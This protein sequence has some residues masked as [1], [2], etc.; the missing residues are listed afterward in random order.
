VEPEVTARLHAAYLARQA[1]EEFL[2]LPEL[3]RLPLPDPV[4]VAPP[5]LAPEP[6]VTKMTPYGLQH[7]Y[8]GKPTLFPSNK[9]GFCSAT[10]KNQLTR[11]VQDVAS[12]IA[13]HNNIS[14][15][16]YNYMHYCMGPTV[17]KACS[18][19]NLDMQRNTC[20][21]PWD[22]DPVRITA[23][24]NKLKEGK[25]PLWLERGFVRQK[26]NICIEILTGNILGPEEQ[27]VWWST[28]KEDMKKHNVDVDLDTL[29]NPLA[30]QVPLGIPLHMPG[31]HSC[32]I[33]NIIKF[34]YKNNF[35]NRF[36]HHQPYTQLVLKDCDRLVPDSPVNPPDDMDLPT[37]RSSLGPPHRKL[38]LTKATMNKSMLRPIP[39]PDTV[40]FTKTFK[41]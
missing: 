39:H 22:V 17:T 30:E 37:P 7:L 12:I 24:Q 25:G 23:L 16:Y 28:V 33:A 19:A 21:N 18:L 31:F 26:F 6:F 35:T 2:P 13:P 8:A 10:S 4:T 20:F 36:I 40:K 41:T 15:W 29:G 38:P 1:A 14:Q 34:V 32:S 11:Q 9:P 3:E 5:C 27:Q